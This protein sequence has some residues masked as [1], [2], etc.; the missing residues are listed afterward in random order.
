MSTDLPLSDWITVDKLGPPGVKGELHVLAMM[1]NETRSDTE[2]LHDNHHRPFKI[3]A[4]LAKAPQPTGDIQGNFGPNDGS[5]Y[6]QIPN[7]YVMSRVRCPDGMFEI[8]KNELG[9]QSLI[10][11]EC[12]ANSTAEA[13]AKFVRAVLPFLDYQAFLANCPL[14]VTTIRVEDAANLRTSID[15]TA[16]YR[17]VVI[18]PHIKFLPPELE[19]VYALY[20]DA[21][22]SHSTFY[23]FLCYHKILEGLLGTMRANI[24][25]RATKKKIELT[26]RRELVPDAEEVPYV[27]RDYIGKP[28]KI[29]FDK[30][31]TPEFRNAVAHFIAKDGSVLNLSSPQEADRYNSILY[32]SELCVRVV[33]QGHEGWLAEIDAAK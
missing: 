8:K 2:R 23:S 25:T 21:K 22:N 31:M 30:V 6:L 15:Y 29:F 4:R 12:E 1:E 5:S 33:I 3:A 26:P 20:R 19:P 17:A 18:N 14:F 24:R 28:I 10:E 32:I 11:F 13:K 9:E 7:D 16:P 27:F